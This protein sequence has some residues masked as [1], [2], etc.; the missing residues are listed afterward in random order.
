MEELVCFLLPSE[1]VDVKCKA[2]ELVLGLSGSEDGRKLIKRPA[3]VVDRILVL[4]ADQNE[5]I[6]KNA[7]MVIVNLSTDRNLEDDL[8]RF[9][10]EFLHHLQ[11]PQWVHADKLCTILSNLSRSTTGAER[12]LHMLTKDEHSDKEENPPLSTPTL[13]QL[14]DIFDRQKSFSSQVKFHYLASIFLNLSQLAEARLMFLD[15]SKCLLLRLLPY[16]QFMDSCIRRGGI[17]GLCKNLCFEVGQ[18]LF[19]IIMICAR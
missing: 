10:P 6:S 17:V 19:R 18:F 3:N 2:L 4:F 11:D 9:V 8:L 7:H 12:L 13:Y 14:V 1:R 15:H 16:S 5:V